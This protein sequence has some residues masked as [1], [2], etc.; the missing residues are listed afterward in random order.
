MAGQAMNKSLASRL[1]AFLFLAATPLLA[2]CGGPANPGNTAAATPEEPPLAGARIGGPF[3]LTDQNGKPASWSD[4]AGK[5]RVVYFGYTYCPDVCPIDLQA[6][7]QGYRAF[8]KAHPDRA[9]RVQPIFITVDPERDTAAVMKTYAAAMGDNLV[10][11][12]GTP[13]QIA[14]VAKAFAVVYAKE[15][16][17]GST[18]YLVG[19]SRTPY[20]FGP[21]GE[22]MA[23][24]PVGE[25]PTGQSVAQF[26]EKWVT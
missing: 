12:T 25:D 14:A 5:Y 26:L 11:L 13:D 20:L 9:A 16:D 4:F 1:G 8:A 19:H 6:I 15:G 17:P 18:D 22:P 3:T 7:M 2:G 24:V 21:G 10:A 23:L